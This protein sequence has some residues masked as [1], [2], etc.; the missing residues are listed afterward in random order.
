MREEV[1]KERNQALLFV[2]AVLAIS[3]SFEV[4]IIV[5]G[6]VKNFGPRWIVVLMCIPGVLSIALR[7]ILNLGFEDAGLRIG[8]GRF[9]IYAIA[10]P[11]LSAFLT[12][13]ASAAFDI[14]QFSMVSSEQL[15]QLS[16]VLLYVL[17]LGLIGAFGEE[18]GWRGFLLPKL[19]SGGVKS[20]YLVSGIVWAAWHV[21]LIA[22][23][24]FYQ[25]DNASL[26][27]LM[28]AL[29]IIAMSFVFSELRMRS[30]SVWV[31]TL[32][33]AAHNFLFQFA[34]PVLLLTAAGSRSELWDTVAGDTGLC[35]AALYAIAYLVLRRV[36]TLS[37]RGRLAER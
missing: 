4:F 25:T 20:P 35:I 30:G 36:G 8:K 5:H 37:A 7:L 19:V 12:G 28:Y 6:G 27:A 29:G 21:P 23:G 33:H 3:W 11:F 31:A 18:L 22:F 17:L 1:V 13:L 16:P 24:G 2:A 9:Y 14:R 26:M 34:V 32:A 15:T 10:V